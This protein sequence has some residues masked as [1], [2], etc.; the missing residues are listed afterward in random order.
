MTRMNQL[1]PRAT[2]QMSLNVSSIRLSIEIATKISSTLP[3]TP[4][5]PL[6]VFWMN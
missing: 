4:R 1:R 6:R 3:V 5:V 2:P